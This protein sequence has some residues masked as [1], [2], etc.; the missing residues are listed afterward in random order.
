MSQIV[1]RLETHL[2]SDKL[3]VPNVDEFKKAVREQIQMEKPASDGG[4]SLF[5]AIATARANAVSLPATDP[6]RRTRLEEL[7]VLAPISAFAYKKG[8]ALPA[9]L[10][11]CVSKAGN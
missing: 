7:L 4:K 8:I 6:R 5:A 2:E 11:G 9:K 1:H 10:T 3:S